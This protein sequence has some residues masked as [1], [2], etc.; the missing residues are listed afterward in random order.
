[1]ITLFTYKE[2]LHEQA[3]TFLTDTP[4]VKAVT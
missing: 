3:A 2:R 4:E 1:M